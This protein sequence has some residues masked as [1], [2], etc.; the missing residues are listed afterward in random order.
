MDS[1]EDNDAV[2]RDLELTLLERGLDEADGPLWGR[3]YREEAPRKRYRQRTEAQR[4]R[5]RELAARRRQAKAAARA[6]PGCGPGAG[7]SDARAGESSGAAQ[8]DG[9]MPSGGTDTCNADQAD[10]AQE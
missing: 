6:T 5:E 9:G 1:D 7:T 2:L 4:E 3:F 8:L 10:G